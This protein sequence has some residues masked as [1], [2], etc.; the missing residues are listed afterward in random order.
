MLAQ[1][2]K[3]FVHLECGRD[4]L[5]Q[6]GGAN[7]PLRNAELVLGQLEDIVPKA[8]LEMALHFRQVK[9]G[10]APARDQLFRVVEKVEAEIEEPARDRF[11]IDENMLFDQMP[12]AWPNEQDG[13]LLIEL[14]LFP[15]RICE[16]DR[17]PNG[18]A[19][20]DLALNHVD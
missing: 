14:I 19:Q 15:V 10:A 3:D 13:E 9:I 5:D 16:R 12:P 1:L 17:A 8:R 18:V 20:I 4:R 11:A 2:V 7:R 6:N